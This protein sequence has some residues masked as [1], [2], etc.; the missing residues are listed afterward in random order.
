MYPVMLS[1][2]GKRVLVVGG[3]E[4]ALRKTQGVLAEGAIPKVIA[5]EVVAGLEELEQKGAIELRRRC[6]RPGDASGFAL[7]FAATDDPGVNAR[8]F[9]EAQQAGIWVNVADEPAPAARVPDKQRGVGNLVV[10]RL[11]DLGPPLVLTEQEAVVRVDDQ[12]GILPQ[13]QRVHQI[14]HLAEVAVAHAH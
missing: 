10:E 13:V 11:D 8:V 12:Q 14:Q 3:G 6:Y 7:V 1:L 4:V 9:G 2:R 5:P